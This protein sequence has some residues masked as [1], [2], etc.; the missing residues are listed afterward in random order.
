MV[1][2]GREFIIIKMKRP[3][4]VWTDKTVHWVED[5]VIYQFHLLY[6]VIDNNEAETEAE[7][8]EI[9]TEWMKSF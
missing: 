3:D 9:I 4:G 2:N 7:V 8:D 5:K 6:S 1:E